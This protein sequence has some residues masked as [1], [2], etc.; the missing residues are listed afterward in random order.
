MRALNL[1]FYIE[2]ELASAILREMDAIT[3]RNR[4]I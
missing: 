1:A 4:R 3:V 2:S